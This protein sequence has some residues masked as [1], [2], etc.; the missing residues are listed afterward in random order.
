M[1]KMGRKEYIQMVADEIA[2]TALQHDINL[3]TATGLD[4]KIA[5]NIINNILNDFHSCDISEENFQLWCNKRLRTNSLDMEA[6]ILCL[7]KE[8]DNSEE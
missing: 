1:N 5:T 8:F 7:R 4:I 3:H 6:E 2:L